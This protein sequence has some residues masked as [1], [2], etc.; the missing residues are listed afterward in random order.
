MD[1]VKETKEAK[2]EEHITGEGATQEENMKME[3]LLGPEVQVEEG[4]I[5]KARVIGESP[6]G[7]L[8]DIGLKSEG[9]I[10]K[11]ELE[12]ASWRSEITE[13]KEIPVEVVSLRT[14]NGHPLVSFR[15]VREREAWERLAASFKNGETVEGTI[16]RKIKGGFM[17][18]IGVDAFLPVSQLDIRFV[19]N[20]D[21]YLDKTLQFLIT[22]LNRG[23]RNVVLSRRKLLE[24]DQKAKKE[25]TMAALEEGQVIE[26][27]VTGITGFGAFIDIGGVEGL[28]HIGDIAWRH[29]NKVE[30]MVKT[31]QKVQVQVLKIDREK[32]KISLGMKQITPRPWNKAVEKYPVGSLV[33]GKIT[34][35][36]DFGLFVE[37][38]PG[39]EGL[40]HVS[41]ISWEERGESLL[42]SFSVGQEIEPKIIALD[43]EKEK[44]S[45]SLKRTQLNPWEEA[46][47]RY[48]SGTKVK[49]T[50]THLTPFGAFVK[51]PEG[52]EGL[53]HVSDM[54]WTKKVRHPQD[55]VKV[56]QEVEV[57]VLDV[58]PQDE[59]ISLSLKHSAEDPF[60]KYKP[61][62]IVTGV[63]KRVMEFGAF[64]ELE[65][66]IEAL[67]RVSE[68]APR[69][70][71]S[72]AEVLKVGQS[73]EAKVIKSEPRERKIDISIKRLD[74]DRERD[75]VRKYANQ[76]EERPTLGDMLEEDKNEDEEG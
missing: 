43:P 36:T 64:V 53:I 61:G 8:V 41:E 5:I 50:V 59:K 54:S 37:V 65:N 45:L 71:E 2:K 20:P 39:I 19:K 73:V 12:G 70:I 25:K 74:Q 32:E 68:I 51:L 9:M 52:I 48:P 6:E 47:K 29:I 56:G 27:L 58:N 75:L 4:K 1:E 18:D 24:I 62:A 72:P 23:Q 46:K 35:I 57:V 10:P 42:K 13:G 33:K 63:V 44:L 15:K 31:G 76:G 14:E 28:L 66:G 49:G 21:K 3:E 60:R 40:L 7:V 69:R 67:V 17:V 11:S 22:E 16:R 38:E 55:F 34:S 26:G 30:D